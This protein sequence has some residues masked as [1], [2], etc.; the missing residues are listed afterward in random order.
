MASNYS[1]GASY[2]YPD[3]QVEASEIL[4]KG[5]RVRGM[6]LATV[7]AELET[8]GNHEDAMS[9]Y[10]CSLWRAVPA[11]SSERSHVVL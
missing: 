10:C 7:D 5:I 3:L 11:I 8:F 6:R 4:E 9:P 1:Y 2:K